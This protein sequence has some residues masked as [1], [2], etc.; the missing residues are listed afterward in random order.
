MNDLD[1]SINEFALPRE[2]L[3]HVLNCRDTN[4]VVGM[5]GNKHVLSLQE[6][7]SITIPITGL[8]RESWNYINYINS[9]S[10]PTDTT[11]ILELSNSVCD[12]ALQTQ[13]LSSTSTFP[14][15]DVSHNIKFQS[16]NSSTIVL[17]D[18][19]GYD[20]SQLYITSPMLEFSG[21]MF[22]GIDLS[23]TCNGESSN[24][25][26][27]PFR[28]INGKTVSPKTGDGSNATTTYITNNSSYGIWT[29]N[30][31]LT[32]SSITTTTL[33][34]DHFAYGQW[35]IINTNNTLL[36]I[37]AG[38]LRSL[39][40]YYDFSSI[41]NISNLI[42]NFANSQD[43]SNIYS[44]QDL[45]I[46]TYNYIDI[47][48]NLF[49][50]ENN[51]HYIINNKQNRI[52]NYSPGQVYNFKFYD[53][54]ALDE[55]SNLNPNNSN[56]NDPSSHPIGFILVS[57]GE[58]LHLSDISVT[59]NFDI[60]NQSLNKI[61]YQIPELSIDPSSSSNPVISY[62]LPKGEY[63]PSYLTLASSWDYEDDILTITMPSEGN[64]FLYC[65]HHGLMASP[66]VLRPKLL[67]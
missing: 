17:G 59:D 23:W 11:L 4:Y 52:F 62:Y 28:L 35:P 24:S 14:P 65:M 67:F 56:I 15:L 13:Y 63:D 3:H 18:T 41:S 60:S 29:D 8:N 45:D 39:T 38:Q 51:P 37:S 19:S 12:S 55:N 33:W 44:T 42:N 20:I 47:C 57:S 5:P 64:I 66:L 6:T 16:N 48:T 26:A 1:T 30:F 58:I 7:S 49:G 50:I 9:F 53:P 27:H 34:I 10:L 61:G 32:Y 36:D 40:T 22:H 2:Q 46:G 54:S 25:L 43:F 31:N 21:I